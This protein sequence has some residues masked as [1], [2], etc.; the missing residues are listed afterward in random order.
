MRRFRHE[1]ERDATL[2][3]RVGDATV[4][5]EY[6]AHG[7][8][9]SGARE[10]MLDLLFE[11]WLT[12]QQAGRASL[13]VA[14]DADTVDE[15]NTR[16]RAWRVR[17]GEV[18][19]GGVRCGDGTIVGVGDVVVTRL[20]VRA[21]ATGRGWVKNGDDWVVTATGEDGSLRVTPARRG[22]CRGPARRTTCASTSSSGTP[23]PHTV[24]RAGPWTPP[25]RT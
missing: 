12:D 14:A 3:L 18:S 17:A 8:V 1:W 9:E 11:G 19:E 5:E 13:M 10:D 20:N 15:L 16:A 23:P 22:S 24:H 6:A 7:R 25:T 21:L 2:R 4:A